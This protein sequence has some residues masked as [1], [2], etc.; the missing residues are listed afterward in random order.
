MKKIIY[1]FIFILTFINFFKHFKNKKKLINKI[2]EIQNAFKENKIENFFVQQ[3]NIRDDF[4]KV[5]AFYVNV[6]FILRLKYFKSDSKLYIFFLYDFL[7]GMY[8]ASCNDLEELFKFYK[9]VNLPFNKFLEKNFKSQSHNKGTLKNKIKK[10]GYLF[11]YG[12]EDFSNA[13]SD[14]MNSYINYHA[15]KYN[16]E[17]F[18]YF[19]YLYDEEYINN[20][21]LKKVKVRKFLNNKYQNLKSLSDKIYNDE[22]DL[23]I[24]DITSSISSY[25][26]H[27]NVA[28]KIIRYD[29]GYPY[30]NHKNLDFTLIQAIK[31][32]KLKQVYGDNY[33]ICLPPPINFKK[34]DNLYLKKDNGLENN[35]RNFYDKEK[36]NICV[37]G[38]FA[39]I[40]KNFLKFVNQILENKD[41]KILFIG[42]G[43]YK[44]IE[45]ILSKNDKDQ[46]T[47][48]NQNMSL[49]HLSKYCDIVLDTFSSH[50]G[51]TALH[52]QYFNIP[53]LS[54]KDIDAPDF[55]KNYRLSDLVFDDLE[56]MKRF[57][58]NL[59]E[60]KF[61]LEKYGLESYEKLI[62]FNE[63]T[64]RQNVSNFRDL[65]NK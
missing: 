42:E 44:N 27:N 34:Y 58:F 33:S 62:K 22:I 25:I 30:W 52:L 55:F 32:K 7:Y 8:W 9:N 4:C 46:F 15:K 59:K 14:A 21:F 60:N 63:V 20:K 5:Y 36:L 19:N 2:F 47:I 43:H 50:N 26:T 40:N 23:L 64:L 54:F 41:I 48:I 12:Y 39:K 53:V 61:K 31:Y 65:I 17:I 57:I 28:K 1:F 35:I 49:K 29:H 11:H 38:R 6:I 13:V 3:I 10:V 24:I 45:N 51:M 56:K 18:V 16:D 37:P